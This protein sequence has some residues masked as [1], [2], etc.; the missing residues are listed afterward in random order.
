MSRKNKATLSPN[1]EKKSEKFTHGDLLRRALT[2][3]FNDDM[4]A[5]VRLHGI[6]KWKPK[7]LVIL[8]VLWEWSGKS[9]LH[10]RTAECC[11]VELDWSLVGLWIIQL[12]PVKEQ[13]KIDR[14]PEHSSVSLSLVI[15][16][17][18]MDMSHETALNGS[19]LSRQ[20][21]DAVQDDYVRSSSKTAP[22][23][24]W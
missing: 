11:E 23:S 6:I 1:T 19:V 24:P 7:Q 18:T 9:T 16:Q 4:F 15:I 20:W 5:D 3:V 17:D 13:I 10:S 2:W 14:P 12:F 8:A 21:I 22:C